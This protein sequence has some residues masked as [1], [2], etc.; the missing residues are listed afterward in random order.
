[1]DIDLIEGQY[2]DVLKYLRDL[3]HKG[4]KVITHPLMGSIKPNETPFRSLIAE[5]GEGLDF[6]SLSIIE[7]SI[8]SCIK[9][10]KDKPAPQWGEKAIY[11]FQVVDIHLFESA[12]QSIKQ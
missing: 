10:L 4:Y 12:L 9:F 7:S 2:L 11:D 1:M 3:V 6:Q 5:A 8:E